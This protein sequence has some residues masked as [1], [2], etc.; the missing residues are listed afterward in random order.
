MLSLEELGYGLSML[1]SENLLKYWRYCHMYGVKNATRLAFRRL[2]KPR[3]RA[4]TQIVPLR[5]PLSLTP[6]VAPI[7]K[8]VSVVIPTKN[9]GNEFKELLKRLRTQGGIKKCEIIL[10]DSGS[11]DDTIAMAE[12]QGALV[13][14]IAPEEFTHGFAR[15]RGAEIASGEYI[16]F[17]V[18]DAWPLTK[19]WLWE[20][21]TALEANKLAAISCAEYPRSNCDLFYQFLIHTQYQCGV[22]ADRSLA[23]DKSCSSYL[24]LRSNAQLSD[25]AALLPRD[26][27]QRYH[28]RTAYAEDLDLGIRLI[29]DGYK[30]G[31]LH[32][33]RVL[34]SHN[35]SAHYFLKRAYV[36]V[37]F[38]V[39]VFPNFAYPEIDDS[40]R[41]L[42]DI[43]LL[44]RSICRLPQMACSRNFPVPVGELMD[45]VRA[46][47]GLDS[48]NPTFRAED[49]D[50]E[51]R[52]FIQYL[53]KFVDGCGVGS[54]TSRSM[55]LPHILGQFDNFRN[56]FLF[57]YD[58][59][60][61]QLTRE[62]TTVVEKIFALHCG[63]HLAYLYLTY[64]ERSGPNEFMSLLDE[65]LR[66]GV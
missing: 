62:V 32:S 58:V 23:W 13:L 54:A 18:Q 52:Q 12:K 15:N 33:V 4:P 9:A 50:P 27:F 44:Y 42:T 36:D 25:I 28:Y 6:E 3:G 35:R 65:H 48:Q 26:V 53:S 10:V 30:I 1:S 11:T 34:H 63:T 21:V 60:D 40:A 29:R 20:M 64:R 8:T 16:L 2:R 37:R 49:V 51:L 47:I 39:D 5:A 14:H 56:W 57:I 59:A 17:T 31:F 66:S 22:K 41:L 45:Q 7:E 46:C 24:G 38:L 43:V 55:I 19:M 61:E